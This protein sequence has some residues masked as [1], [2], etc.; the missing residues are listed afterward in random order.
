MHIYV[1]IWI[2]IIP[3]MQKYAK[4]YAKNALKYAKYA[5]LHIHIAYFADIRSALFA[6]ESYPR[7][8][9]GVSRWPGAARPSE[10]MAAKHAEST[11][12][13]Y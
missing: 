2:Q 12:P 9:A 5:E 13:L 10:S 6:D 3:N 11:E 8:R 1:N 4:K 7:A